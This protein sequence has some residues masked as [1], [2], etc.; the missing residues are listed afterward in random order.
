MPVSEAAVGDGG[1]V[2]DDETGEEDAK[3]VE[4]MES[5]ARWGFILMSGFGKEG[6][7]A[8]S[9]VCGHVV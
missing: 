7:R 5:I 1:V 8:V 3:V 2:N 6:V 4:M 9:P